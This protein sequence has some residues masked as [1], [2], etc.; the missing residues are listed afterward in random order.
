MVVI[1]IG[2]FC[3]NM[4]GHMYSARTTTPSN[5]LVVLYLVSYVHTYMYLV[6]V[7]YKCD[8]LHVPCVIE[9]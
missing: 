5:N 1:I 8:C 3:D 6:V 9:L 4:V 7:C 2:W